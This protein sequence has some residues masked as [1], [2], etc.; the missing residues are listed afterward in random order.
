MT[1][2]PLVVGVADL[3]HHPGSR[4]HEHLEAPLTPL[5]VVG[6]SVPAGGPVRVDALLEQVSDGILASGT[7]TAGW[8]GECRRCLREIGGELRAEFRELFER[9]PTEGETYPLVHETVNLELPVREAL[10]LELPLAP[11]CAPDCRGIC[12]TCGVNRNDLAEGV[13]CE[14]PPPDRDPRWAALDALRGDDS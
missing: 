1:A 10:T 2:G 13:A 4:R 7:A 14:C 11:L 6:N 12:P 5:R 8:T 3:L 9:N